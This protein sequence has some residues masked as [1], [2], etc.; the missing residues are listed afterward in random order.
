MVFGGGASQ[1]VWHLC[2][3][4]D[5]LLEMPDLSQFPKLKELWCWNTTHFTSFPQVLR[6]MCWVGASA[7]PQG[8]EEK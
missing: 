4:E 3:R 8:R 1:N 2:V 6:K 5:T 7:L